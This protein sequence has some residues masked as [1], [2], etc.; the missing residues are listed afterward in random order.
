MLSR[1]LTARI[2]QC[3]SG[4]RFIDM[5]NRRF[6]APAMR[7]LYEAREDCPLTSIDDIVVISPNLRALASELDAALGV[8]KSSTSGRVGN[9]LYLL[10][11]TSGSP[12]L[13]SV[14]DYA[15]I[16]VLA[17][18]RIGPDRAAEL[19]SGWLRDEPVRPRSCWLLKGIETEKPLNPVEGL[20]IETLAPA[21][22]FPRATIRADQYG[23]LHD[24]FEKRTLLTVHYKTI[25]GLYDPDSLRESFPPD[26]PRTIVNPE[27]ESL[28]PQGF[29]QAMSLEV[30]GYVDWFEQ[31]ND[32]EDVE[33]FSLQPN[34]SRMVREIRSRS[35]KMI[36]AEHVQRALRTD[37][38]LKRSPKL[39]VPAARW[40][41]S[42]RSPAEHEQLIEL[43]IALESVLLNDDDNRHAEKR[44]RLAVR[45]AWLLAETPNERKDYYGLLQTVYDHAS[46]VIHGGQLKP[47]KGRDVAEDIAAAQDLCRDA[48]LRTARSK[49]K[50]DWSDLILDL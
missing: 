48:I 8:Y 1:S 37:D 18:A 39:A 33:A 27:L 45:G 36:T 13:P 4:A 38:L 26:I 50:W 30:N 46:V 5:F 6:D 47:K 10:M 49:Q 28:I 24:N 31:R 35:T 42:K 21:L 23:F 41:R 32:Y 44:H 11:G 43:R 40:L 15:K 22:D 14:A 20:R 12:K 9:S 2:D 29:C 25:P 3:L 16:L 19:F 34:C 7:N 17:A